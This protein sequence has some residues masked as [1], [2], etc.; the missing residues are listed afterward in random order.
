M[1]VSIGR[2]LKVLNF[3]KENKLTLC[4]VSTDEY[5]HEVLNFPKENKLTLCKVSTD[6]YTL[7]VLN[8]P[9]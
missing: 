8:F 5:T 7:E 6:E 3:P 4:K 9:K 1:H 2:K